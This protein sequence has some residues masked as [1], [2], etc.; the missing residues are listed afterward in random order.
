MSAT[1]P[2][3]REILRSSL[4]HDAGFQSTFTINLLNT[5]QPAFKHRKT[6]Q[7]NSSCNDHRTC[8]NENLPD[9]KLPPRTC[10]KASVVL[11]QGVLPSLAWNAVR[12]WSKEAITWSLFVPSCEYGV[13][14]ALNFI[15][16]PSCVDR[17][18]CVKDKDAGISL[19]F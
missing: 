19:L 13:E 4:V 7:H 18:S 2:S 10:S 8:Q 5:L 9:K 11:R 14:R 12:Q 1:D 6:T 17:R 15:S 16:E 3:H